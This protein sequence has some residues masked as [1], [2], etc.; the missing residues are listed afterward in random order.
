MHN[1]TYWLFGFGVGSLA[2]LLLAPR[3]G[4]ATRARIVKT[5]KKRE[6]EVRRRL[7]TTSA[8]IDRGITGAMR[9]AKRLG[10]PTNKRV[11]AS[12]R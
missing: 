4:A 5:A 8:A 11:F 10:L 2:G 12:F 3:A 6:R 1:G 9:T 7:T